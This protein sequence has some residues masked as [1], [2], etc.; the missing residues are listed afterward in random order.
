MPKLMP[1][2]SSAYC[3]KRHQKNPILKPTDVPYKSDLVF[4]AAVVK[5][6]EMYHMLFRNDY[7]YVKEALFSGTNLGIAD[8]ADGVKW[9]V[10]KQ[11]MHALEK[12]LNKENTRLYD[13][14]LTYIDSE[15]YIC[16]A[17]DT[18]HGLRGGIGRIIGDFEDMEIISLS[19]P[20]N[21]N[22]VLFPEKI[23]GMYVRLERPM[24]VYSRGG[25]DRF[26][27]WISKSPD[28]KFWG[29]SELLIGVEDVPYANDKIGPAAPPIKTPYGWLVNFHAVDIDESRGKNG[30]ES[31]WKKRYSMGIMLLDLKDPTKVLGVYKSPLIAPEADYEVNNGF[32]EN[33]IFACGSVME[34]DGNVKMYYG[35]ADIVICLAEANVDDLVKLC[36][37]DHR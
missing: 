29:E 32:R 19:V 26:D 3:I 14:R 28:L 17:L 12:Y 7:G 16:F 35:A 21:R 37:S 20:D 2:L 13:P 9:T 22:M 11:P 4:N 27:I 1:P 34:K 25:K 15:L 30:W 33:A 10:R 36:L 6:D 24:P 5:H 18:V 23:D 31:A 8:S